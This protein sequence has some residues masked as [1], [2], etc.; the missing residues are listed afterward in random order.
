MLVGTSIPEDLMTRK[1]QNP[2]D[3]ANPA[4]KGKGDEPQGGKAQ[5]DKPKG[6]QVQGEGNYEASHRYR[7]GVNEFLSHA[8]V[9]DIAHKAAP[10]S[11]LEERELALAAKQGQLRSKGDDPADVA[12]MYPGQDDTQP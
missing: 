11:P 1:T 3:R 9:E 10:K 5:G 7:D 8:D 2:P 6:D 4:G 12:A